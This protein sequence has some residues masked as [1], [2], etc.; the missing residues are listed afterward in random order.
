MASNYFRDLEAEYI[1][2]ATSD[3]S[4][5]PRMPE[6]ESVWGDGPPLPTSYAIGVTEEM[7]VTDEMAAGYLLDDP[8]G[9][10]LEPEYVVGV[11]TAA[12][13]IVGHVP[14]EA[15]MQDAL[16]DALVS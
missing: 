16:G 1:A 7:A 8:F 13:A 15:E 12:I 6:A 5:A 14:S 9:A 2:A 4:S 3:D 10:T 11:V